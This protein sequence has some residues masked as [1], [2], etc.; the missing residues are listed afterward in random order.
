MHVARALKWWE[1]N[2]ASNMMEIKSTN[3]LVHELLN[4][5][6]RLVIVEFFSPG[7]RG[8]R[9]LHPKICQQAE[10]NPSAIFLE[11]NYDHH[12]TMCQSLHIKVLPFFQFYRGAQGRV[13]SFSCTNTTIKKFKDAIA[14]HGIDRHSLGPAKG[15]E[16]PELIRLASNPETH[17]S[18]P[19]QSLAENFA[20]SIFADSL[21]EEVEIADRAAAMAVRLTQGY[22]DT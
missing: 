21:D 19:L 10:L 3:Q 1:K 7:C 6:D 5:G 12:R 13:N 22:T 16:E 15:L 9:A 14:K 11:V 4:A 2:T 18:Y 8:C 20:L 17:F